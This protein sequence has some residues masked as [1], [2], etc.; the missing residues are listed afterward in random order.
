MS[1]EEK[2]IYIG[3]RVYFPSITEKDMKEDPEKAI[4]KFREESF[5]VD[6]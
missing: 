6:V 2:D 5:E 1:E 3:R 4:K